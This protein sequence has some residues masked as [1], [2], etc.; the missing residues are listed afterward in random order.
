MMTDVLLRPATPS[1][2][3]QV[4][5]LLER[6]GLPTSDVSLI[7]ESFQIAIYEGLIVGCAAAEHHGTSV[8]IR[9]AAVEAAYRDRGIATR[10]V[11][12]LLMRA[13]GT[14]ARDA[15]VFS[16]VAPAYFARWGFTLVAN[17]AVPQEVMS[18]IAAQRATRASA[19]CMRCELR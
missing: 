18:S 7:I 1:D 19:L 4:A 10:I 12:A 13:R 8:L 5:A 16:V 2:W 6:C 9:S 11:D 17:E 15:Y 3:H 14:E